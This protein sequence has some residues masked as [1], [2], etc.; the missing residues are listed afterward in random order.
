MSGT[1]TSPEVGRLGAIIE[2]DLP[3]HNYVYPIFGDDNSEAVHSLA[4][5]LL[6]LLESEDGVTATGDHTVAQKQYGN[7]VVAS[8]IEGASAGRSSF[9]RVKAEPQPG[10]YTELEVKFAGGTLQKVSRTGKD[11]APRVELLFEPDEVRY[12]LTLV[13]EATTLLD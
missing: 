8:G 4:T 2:K 13:R 5:E 3:E 11:V 10:A 6:G 7:V 1:L 12:W 9:V